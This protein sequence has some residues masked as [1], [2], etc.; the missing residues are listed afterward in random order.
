MSP[1]VGSI[2]LEVIEPIATDSVRL[3]HEERPGIA[4][5]QIDEHPG[6]MVAIRVVELDDALERHETEVEGDLDRSG[7]VVEIE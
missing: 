5:S 6:L 1:D 7:Q 4:P 2:A 3:G